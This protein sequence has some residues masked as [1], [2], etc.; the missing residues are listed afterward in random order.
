MMNNNNLNQNM[1]PELEKKLK[2]YRLS[3]EEYERMKSLLKREPL[4]VEWPLFSALW[5]EHCSYKSS[6]I[7]LRKFSFRNEMTPDLDGENA[8]VVDLG[9]DEKI[10]FKMESHNHP[11]FIE[12]VQGAATGVGGILRDIFTM[13]ARPIMSA[14]YLCFGERS[15]DRMEYLMNGVVHGISM[16]GNCVGVP[17]VTGQTNVH[18]K[19][20]KNILV[21]AMSVGY[22]GPGQKMALS[23][24]AGPGNYV[25]YVGAKTGRDGVHGAS[26]AS[27]LE[28]SIANPVFSIISSGEEAG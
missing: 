20:N 15:A 16:Y 12:P 17:T 23:K 7:H 10:A 18:P 8:G 3:V 26:M 27:A 25:V 14:D 4:P 5:S 1:N 9:Y 19:Y 6:K 21:N 13:G 22:F 2:L 24:A 11:S 28:T